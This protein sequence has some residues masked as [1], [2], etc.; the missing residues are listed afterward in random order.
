MVSIVVGWQEFFAL[1]LAGF[2]ILVTGMCLYNDIIFLP[3]ARY[4]TSKLG[5]VESKVAEYRTLLDEGDNGE[6]EREINLTKNQE[7]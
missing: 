1:Q 7:D 5:L 4:L 3:I 6:V 2:C